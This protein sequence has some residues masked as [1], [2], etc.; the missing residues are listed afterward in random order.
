V[1]KTTIEQALAQTAVVIPSIHRRTRLERLLTSIDLPL[2]Q[3]L[4]EQG[5]SHGREAC[6]RGLGAMVLQLGQQATF[7]Q[8]CNDWE[9][10]SSG[11]GIGGRARLAHSSSRPLPPIP[12][13]PADNYQMICQDWMG[14]LPRPMT[15][16]V[17]SLAVMI[18]GFRVWT[19]TLLTYL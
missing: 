18:I 11:H 2:E 4:V 12:R 14:R 13:Q 8:A 10:F 9:S 15:R 19:R 3:V 5:R 17:P 6:C 1:I 7:T 16:S